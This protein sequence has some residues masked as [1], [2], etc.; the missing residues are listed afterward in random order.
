MSQFTKLVIDNKWQSSL[1]ST[2]IFAFDWVTLHLSLFF[3]IESEFRE[4][5]PWINASKF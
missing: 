4:T 3:V 1:K 5:G 2:E